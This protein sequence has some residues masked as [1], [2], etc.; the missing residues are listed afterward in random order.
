[1]FPIPAFAA[2]LAFGE[3]ADE[4]M[5]ASTR[6]VPSKLTGSGYKFRHSEL[7]VALEHLL[8]RADGV[9]TS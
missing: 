5:L 8:K 2:R 3:M 6:A 4:L 7:V 9:S 1:M